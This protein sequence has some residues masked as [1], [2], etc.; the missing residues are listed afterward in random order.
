[1][2][3][4]KIQINSREIENLSYNLNRNINKMST[5]EITYDINTN[6]YTY[7]NTDISLYSTDDILEYYFGDEAETMLKNGDIFILTTSQDE[8]DIIMYSGQ[9]IGFGAHSTDRVQG[10]FE[11]IVE[12]TTQTV[13]DTIIGNVGENLTD[14][15]SD[16]VGAIVSDFRTLSTLE[17]QKTCSKFKPVDYAN[18]FVGLSGA[19]GF[20]GGIVNDIILSDYINVVSTNG[21][22]KNYFLGIYNNITTGNGCRLSIADVGD[23]ANIYDSY[24]NWYDEHCND[25]L[26]VNGNSLVIPFD[27]N[28][29]ANKMFELASKEINDNIEPTPDGTDTDTGIE[30][31]PDIAPT[32]KTIIGDNNNNYLYDD[33]YENVPLTIMGLSG[34]D[35]L[36]GSKYSDKLYG[37]SGNDSISGYDGSDYIMGEYGNDSING[38]NDSDTIYGGYGNDSISGGNGSD[39]I[40][41]GMGN[42][43]LSGDAGSDTYLFYKNFGNDSICDS[44]AAGTYENTIVLDSG[45]SLDSLYTVLTTGQHARLEMDGSDDSIDFTYLRIYETFR[46][47]K[48]EVDGKTIT[49]DAEESPFRKI[50]GDENNNVLSPIYAEGTT[51][52]YAGDGNDSVSGA[53]G[54]DVLY[55]DGGNDTIYG[56]NGNDEIYGGTGND[57]LNGGA[58]SDTYYFNAGDGNDVVSDGSGSNDSL[59]FGNG[60][61]I[62]DIIVSRNGNDMILKVNGD[63]DTVRLVNQYSSISNRIENFYFADGTVLTANDYLNNNPTI[64]GSGTVSDYTGGF[65]TGNSTLIGSDED[66]TLYGYAGND[67]LIGGVGDDS[68]YGGAGDDTYIFN[69]GDG[70]DVIDGQGSN[71]L[72]DTVS[73]GEGISAEDIYASQSGNNLILSVL[74]TED[75]VTVANHFSES[76]AVE[77]FTLSDGRAATNT[78]INQLV[79]SM[80]SFESESGM[81]W[82]DAVAQNNETA[83]SI[84]DNIWVQKPAV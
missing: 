63:N 55:G 41:G 28:E 19:D 17:S 71:S 37:G 16:I 73:F 9:V 49:A 77:N 29:L 12:D 79:Q 64:N 53:N 42:D 27:T 15:P 1:M 57:S 13:V 31:A 45:T 72:N 5:A 52:I 35:T 24:L 74:G 14:I 11:E 51:Y 83:M 4:I 6:K 61:S 3:N 54:D 60:I 69:Y 21:A 80:A 76:S 33:K 65:G 47:F 59:A 39:I 32:S 34:N 58:G 66:D 20:I 22:D 68:L 67:T 84:I 40:C 75:S 81:L 30:T 23:G 26:V 70:I 50:R 36:Q 56:G 25:G 8:V 43:S 10:L 62:G 44:A 78:Q 46:Q 82:G 38:G 48:F 7:G 2:S 18:A